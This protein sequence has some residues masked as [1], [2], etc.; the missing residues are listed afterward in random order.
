MELYGTNISCGVYQLYIGAEVSEKVY[1]EQY[2][3][4]IKNMWHSDTP[5]C[6]FMIASLTSLQPRAI[7]FVRSIGFIQSGGWHTN[8][9]TGN[10]IAVFVKTFGK[11]VIP[12]YPGCRDCAQKH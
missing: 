3:A 9:N 12:P 5:K 1:A 11:E 8:P 10:F 2:K 6:G 4:A 7:D